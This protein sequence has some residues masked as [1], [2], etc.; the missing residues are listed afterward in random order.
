[1]CLGRIE[2][3]GTVSGKQIKHRAKIAID[4]PDMKEFMCGMSPNYIHSQ[5]A[6]HMAL[7]IDTWNNEFGAIHDS[8]STH[9]SDVDNLLALTKQTFVEMYDVDNF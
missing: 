8:F 3:R 6:A 1:M 2:T 9:A 5:D 4:V 7:V